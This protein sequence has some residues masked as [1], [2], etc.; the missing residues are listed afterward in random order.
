MDVHKP[1]PWGGWREFLKEYLTIVIGVLT[2]LGAD[3]VVENW[4]WQAKVH[5]V[6]AALQDELRDDLRQAY[7]RVAVEHCQGDYIGTLASRLRS[8]GL[9]WPG[10]APGGGKPPSDAPALPAVYRAPEGLWRTGTWDTAVSSDI[11][12]HVPRERSAF[13][14]TTYRVIERLRGWQDEERALSPRLKPLAFALDLDPGQRL[15]YLGI[16]SQIDS[17]NWETARASRRLLADLGRGGVRLKKSQLE[18]ELKT[19]GWG[20]L[21]CVTKPSVPLDPG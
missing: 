14:V 1:K 15:E 18:Q 7:G 4:R 20:A 16:V 8:S 12:S 6:E 21:S 3:Q 17:L 13:F 2:A 9:R 19:V 10:I 11:L 5:T